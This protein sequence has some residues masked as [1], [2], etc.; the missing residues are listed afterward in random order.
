MKGT[1]VNW[2]FVNKIVVTLTTGFTLLGA[3]TGYKANEETLLKFAEETLK[4]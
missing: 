4:K 3:Y 2:S 1:K